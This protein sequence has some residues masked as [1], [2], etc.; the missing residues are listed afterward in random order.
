MIPHF[1]TLFTQIKRLLK[2]L[3][4]VAFSRLPMISLNTDQMWHLSVLKLFLKLISRPSLLT[5]KSKPLLKS[6]GLF[7]NWRLIN[8]SDILSSR[9]WE[10]PNETSVANVEATWHRRNPP[11]ESSSDQLFLYSA[12]DKTC[13]PTEQIQ[14]LTDLTSLCLYSSVFWFSPPPLPSLSRLADVGYSKVKVLCLSAHGSQGASPVA[15][16]LLWK[17]YI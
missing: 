13:R 17:P 8:I 3:L 2:S 12:E 1:A 5:P 11:Q 4:V 15:F 16:M 14:R 6:L 7:Y 10:L 9:V